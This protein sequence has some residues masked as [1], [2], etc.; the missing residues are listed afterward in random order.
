MFR[1]YLFFLIILFYCDAQA[2]SNYIMHP[3]CSISGNTSNKPLVIFFTGDSGRSS[4]DKKLTDSLCTDTIPL[5]CINSYKYFR[6]RKTPHQTLDS[7]LPYIDLNLKKYNRQKFIFAGY[8]FGSEVVPFIYNLMSDEW[9]DKVEFIVLLSPADNSDFKIHFLDQIGLTFRH[10]SYDVLSEI[11]KI[12]E[13]KVIV[14]W[15][16]D[17]KK[18]EEKQF[19]KFNITVHHLEGGHRHTDILPVIEIIN[20]RITAQNVN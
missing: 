15:G 16:K 19:T 12:E 20:D 2:Q 5:M 13:K 1:K 18:F 11:M 8:S 9:K 10:W 4:F 17:E 7:I 3:E 6:R 14:F